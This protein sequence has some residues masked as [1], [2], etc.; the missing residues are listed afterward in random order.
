MSL[1]FIHGR[2]CQHG[3]ALVGRWFYSCCWRS[4]RPR[5]DLKE[6]RTRICGIAAAQV[7][8]RRPAQSDGDKTAGKLPNAIYRDGTY[9]TLFSPYWQPRLTD[10]PATITAAAMLSGEGC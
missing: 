6:G 7:Y 5:A 8:F 1:R 4:S 9:A 10:L 3:Q 2:R